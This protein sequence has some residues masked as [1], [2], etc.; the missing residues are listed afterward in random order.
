M[1]LF[2]SNT[3]LFCVTERCSSVC[4]V[5]G[6]YVGVEAGEDASLFRRV[7][8]ERRSEEVDEVRETPA[9]TLKTRT[10]T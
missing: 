10:I 2:F 8:F 4:A 5:E 7:L 6:V 9:G 1:V 3:C